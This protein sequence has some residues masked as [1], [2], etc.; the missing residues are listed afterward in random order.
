V[1]ACKGVSLVAIMHAPARA[2]EDSPYA[3]PH[4]VTGKSFYKVF[5]NRDVER[6]LNELRCTP[7]TWATT[8][9]RAFEIGSDGEAE[10]LR[11]E[12]NVG[13]SVRALA[14]TCLTDIVNVFIDN[15]AL[16]VSFHL[17]QPLGSTSSRGTNTRKTPGLRPDYVGVQYHRDPIQY[18][19]VGEGKHI[20][21]LKRQVV[22]LAN[23]KIVNKPL[24]LAALYYDDTKSDDLRDAVHQLYTYMCVMGLKYGFLTT[25]NTW[26]FFTRDVVLVGAEEDDLDEELLISE[27]ITPES[28]TPTLMEAF[29][30]FALT[31]MEDQHAV[32]MKPSPRVAERIQVRY[33]A[34]PNGKAHKDD[35][36]ALQKHIGKALAQEDGSA[37]GD[38][39]SRQHGQSK[40]AASSRFSLSE[41]EQLVA[42]VPSLPLKELDG[43]PMYGQK[44]GDGRTGVTMRAHIDGFPVDVA[45]KIADIMKLEYAEDELKNEYNAYLRMTGLWGTVVPFL[46]W[47]GRMPWGRAGLATSLAGSMTLEE[48]M[49]HKSI[50]MT[51]LERTLRNGLAQIHA[52]GVAHG[53]IAMKNIVV[54][55]CD[56]L[57][58]KF[59]DFGNSTVLGDD[60][61]NAMQVRQQQE[62]DL[63]S[64]NGVLKGAAWFAEARER[65]ASEGE[66]ASSAP[67]NKLNVSDVSV[68]G[69]IPLPY[70]SVNSAP[71]LAQYNNGANDRLADYAI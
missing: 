54:D 62:Q 44:L 71:S 53:D 49:Q 17:E 43:E 19:F 28:T 65:E 26:W 41:F 16:H 39:S 67:A 47:A 56:G 66:V 70:I 27:P 42:V 21:V 8:V 52:L 50:D 13:S 4:C 25:Y 34:F 35:M 57:E 23:K 31:A 22:E 58:A 29:S 18:R 30:L 20:M 64:L 36:T 2:R 1:K 32:D 3:S 38:S 63:A 55:G 14:R 68:S 69:S 24:D 15:K 10:L 51:A 40:R 61:D 5:Y 59:I 11:A 45:I 60:S 48:H 37:A 9:G 33:P 7:L 46:V 6:R 12:S